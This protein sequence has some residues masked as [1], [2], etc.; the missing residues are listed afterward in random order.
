MLDD[1]N[2]PVHRM[3]AYM[4]IP[5]QCLHL[6]G[7]GKE[8]LQNGKTAR[9]QQDARFLGEWLTLQGPDEASQWVRCHTG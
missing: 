8:G 4:H 3:H 2:S 5:V 1:Y 9:T 7:L 6:P